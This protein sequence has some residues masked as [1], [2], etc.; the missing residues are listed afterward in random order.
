MWTGSI[1]PFIR[2][3][4]RSAEK[5]TRPLRDLERRA[6]RRVVSIGFPVEPRPFTY[7]EIE[8]YFSGS[9]SI[10]CLRCGR[11]LRKLGIHL[12]RIHSI[13]DDEY[14]EMY[15]LPW[16]YGLVCRDTREAYASALQRRIDDGE[17]WFGRPNLEYAVRAPRR[18]VQP[19][20][21]E[22]ARAN[23]SLAP[24]RPRLKPSRKKQG[25][26]PLRVNNTSGFTGVSRHPN[27]LWQA[28]FDYQRVH[29]Q[30]GYFKTF[31]EAKAAYLARREEVLDASR[32]AKHWRLSR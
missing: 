21:G 13:S 27:G 14:R 20:R 18:R 22:V 25:T 5:T 19:F 1:S 15:G 31:E 7:D 17:E 29:H 9:D 6:A 26:G 4:G 10:V 3:K 28:Q 23:I 24:K 8:A 12:Q 11:S 32:L 16:T 2:P 30:V